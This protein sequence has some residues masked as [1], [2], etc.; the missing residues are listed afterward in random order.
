MLFPLLFY[1]EL[2]ICVFRSH[3]YIDGKGRIESVMLQCFVGSFWVEECFRETCVDGSEVAAFE[4][5]A[6]SR[7]WFSGLVCRW[8]RSQG[9]LVAR[10]GEKLVFGS[11]ALA[12]AKSQRL[13]ARFGEKMVFGTSV[14][15]GEKLERLDGSRWREDNF[16]DS[17]VCGSEVTAIW[18]LALA[19]RWFSVVVC[20][21]LSAYVPCGCAVVAHTAVQSAGLK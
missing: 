1:F 19:R 6:L 18:W 21:E 17:C 5:F 7:R 11:R 4:W 13:V 12:G 8:E 10:F 3:Q 14:L 15:V 9:V 20:Y 16:R 2:Q